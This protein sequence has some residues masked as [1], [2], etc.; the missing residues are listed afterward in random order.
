MKPTSLVAVV[1]VFI[2]AIA[3]FFI[4]T[5]DNQ[6]PPPPPPPQEVGDFEIL[7]EANDVSFLSDEVGLF[8]VSLHSLQGF[9]SSVRLRVQ[10]PPRGIRIDFNGGPDYRVRS[11]QT[12]NAGISFTLVEEDA[13]GMRNITITATSQMRT[14]S[15]NAT[16][17][18]IGQGT[19]LLTV[20]DFSFVQNQVTV[21]RGTNIRWHNQDDVSHTVTSN[22]DVFD[23]P[24]DSQSICTFQFTEEGTF[25]YFCRPHPLMLGTIRVI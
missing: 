23:M 2:V 9:D 11:D 18:I 1:V 22:E 12:V 14:H 15:I 8:T 4:F 7:V 19:I 10:N 25:N 3:G 20:R 6:P 21:L 13:I 16:L 17:N 5:S 24:L